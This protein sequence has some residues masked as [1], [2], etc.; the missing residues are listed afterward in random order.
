MIRQHGL[1]PNMVKSY[2]TDF[3]GV[4]ALR[5]ATRQQV[6]TFV[7]H[8]ADWAEKDRDGLLCQLNSY[9]DQKAGAA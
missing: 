4:N 9:P 6:E 1:D 3:C 8:L 7:A 2:A 5:E